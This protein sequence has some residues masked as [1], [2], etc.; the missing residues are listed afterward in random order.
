[1]WCPPRLVCTKWPL[2]CDMLAL[3]VRQRFIW[4]W[5]CCKS[6]PLLH[7]LNR[8]AMLLHV[9]AGFSSACH[10][11][12]HPE[13]FN[14]PHISRCC[15]VFKC[16]WSFRCGTSLSYSCFV[17]P[18]VASREE[19]YPDCED[20]QLLQS[21]SRCLRCWAEVFQIVAPSNAPGRCVH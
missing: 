6:T 18:C 20:A 12:T 8:F 2:L 1:M 14:C 17:H 19:T 13:Y 3:L 4:C 15:L 11:L 10:R 5:T 21:P 9:L 7:V 16:E